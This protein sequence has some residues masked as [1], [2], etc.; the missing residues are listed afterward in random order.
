MHQPLEAHIYPP[1]RAT[2]A[3]VYADVDLFNET[4][5]ELYDALDIRVAK[6]MKLGGQELNLHV[7]YQRVRS[8]SKPWVLS[9][10]RM[11]SSRTRLRGCVHSRGALE[12]RKRC[13]LP[14]ILLKPS[15]DRKCCS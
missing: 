15:E 12:E 2:H 13:A 5:K 9:N 3:E 7:L 8:G 10:L 14:M 6:V 11:R 4:L 1:A